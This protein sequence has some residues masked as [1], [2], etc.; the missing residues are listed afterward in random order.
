MARYT[1]TERLGVNAVEKSVLEELEW[2][3]REVPVLDFGIDGQIEIVESGDPKNKLFAVQIKSGNSYLT[4]TAAGKDKYFTYYPSATHYHYWTN[5]SI[6]V[7]GVFR[8]DK[9]ILYWQK[10]SANTIEKTKKGYKLE[11][12][13]TNI[14]DKSCK[15]NL[16]QFHKDWVPKSEYPIL[17]KTSTVQS[18]LGIENFLISVQSLRFIRDSINYHGI[19]FHGSKSKL[20]GTISD[21]ISKITLSEQIEL[22]KLKLSIRILK[23]RINSELQYLTSLSAELFRSY[24]MKI[25]ILKEKFSDDPSIL[26]NLKDE[27]AKSIEASKIISSMA[28][29]IIELTSQVELNNSIHSLLNSEFHELNLL[30]PQLRNELISVIGYHDLINTGFELTIKELEKST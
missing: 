14:F 26:S 10:L 19:N 20:S 5:S 17:D 18:L 3:F 6:P 1:P 15:A 4:E 22:Q 21:D 9:G 23:S 28:K 11:I 13:I 25:E 16:E 27:Y 29:E 12:P 2:L 8:D 30:I 24:V 7:I